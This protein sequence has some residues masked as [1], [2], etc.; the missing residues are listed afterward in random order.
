MQSIDD[1]ILARIRGK[2]RGC[3]FFSTDFTLLGESKSVL[4]AIERLVTRGDILLNQDSI[5]L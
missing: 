2:C 3:V 1:K 4:K 5:S